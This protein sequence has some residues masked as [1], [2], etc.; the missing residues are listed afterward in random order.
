MGHLCWAALLHHVVEHLWHRNTDHRSPVTP[1]SPTNEIIDYL[2]PLERSPE[3]ACVPLYEV[4]ILENGWH[5]YTPPHTGCFCEWTLFI[6]TYYLSM[7]SF[8]SNFWTLSIHL[9]ITTETMCTRD[10]SEKESELVT[11]TESWR[12]EVG[13]CWVHQ[14][15]HVSLALTLHSKTAFL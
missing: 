10:T 1:P 3:K 6:F 15:P 2:I 13:S 7:G 12:G 9:L 8:F 11:Q 14:W 4:A 5:T